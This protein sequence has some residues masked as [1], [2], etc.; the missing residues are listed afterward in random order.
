MAVRQTATGQSREN[1]FVV[2]LLPL[3]HI[4]CGFLLDVGPL[5]S[6]YPKNHM[7]FA[8][9][10]FRLFMGAGFIHGRF[11]MCAETADDS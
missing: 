6:S 1:Q 3:F 8:I 5:F 7:A 11:V 2:S 9:D 4:F 10:N